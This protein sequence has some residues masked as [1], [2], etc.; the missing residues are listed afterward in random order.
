[1]GP[2]TQEHNENSRGTESHSDAG[3]LRKRP[4]VLVVLSGGGFSFQTCRLLRGCPPEC[5]LIIAATHYMHGH[6]QHESY[7]AQKG[8]SHLKFRLYELP[9]LG[10]LSRTSVAINIW[11]SIVCMIASFRILLRERPN[12]V[13]TVATSAS[14]PILFAAKCL[15]V[16]GIFVESLTRVTKPSRT[17]RLI[18]KLRLADRFLVQWPQAVDLYRDCEYGGRVA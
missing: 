5:D 2:E 10:T 16:R 17:G 8:L 4:R 11:R 1:M 9:N 12:A 7:L 6:F 3:M 18:S 13:I 14:V 15:G